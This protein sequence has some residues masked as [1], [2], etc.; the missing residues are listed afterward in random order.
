[1]DGL[2]AAASLISVIELSA[3]ITSLCLQYSAAVKDAKKDIEHFQ[4]KVADLRGVL[5]EVKRLLSTHDIRRLPTAH[6]LEES[7]LDCSQRLAKLEARLLPGSTRKTMSRLGV[8]AL[9]WPFTSKEVHAIVDDLG[10]YEHTFNLALQ[11]DQT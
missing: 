9:K 2:S 11:V 8:R 6:K 1:M 4:R 7:L 5:G 10:R 3:R